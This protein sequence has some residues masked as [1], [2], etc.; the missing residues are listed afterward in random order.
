MGDRD[1]VGLKESKPGEVV[2]YSLDNGFNVHVTAH[3]PAP[4]LGFPRGIVRRQI[5]N[6][7]GEE[8]AAVM[9]IHHESQSFDTPLNQ[10][11]RPLWLGALMIF[12]DPENIELFPESRKR[13]T[14]RLHVPS[15]PE[16]LTVGG[17]L[18]PPGSVY[19]LNHNA[20]SPTAFA[21][22]SSAS[23]WL[24]LAVEPS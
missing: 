22:E 24:V 23:P 21:V 20:L 3:E 2:L 9:L 1:L 17:W 12:T 8:P 4:E 13:Q 7:Q 15:P 18:L 11:G 19:S 14:H 10:L 6:S 5:E 16:F